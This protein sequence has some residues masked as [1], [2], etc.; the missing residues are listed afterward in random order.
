[1]KEYLMGISGDKVFDESLE[2]LQPSV[3]YEFLY[4]ITAHGVEHLADI[5]GWAGV[6]PE[7]VDPRG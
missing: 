7:S 5:Y 3:A 6:E 4:P 1:M 2:S